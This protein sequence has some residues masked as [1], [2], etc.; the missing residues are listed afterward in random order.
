MKFT[1]SIGRFFRVIAWGTGQDD[2]KQIFI[3]F[4]EGG[5]IVNIASIRFLVP[6][7]KHY[8]FTGEYV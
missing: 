3:Y 7:L 8:S 2:V 1:H 4:Q 6:Q 5:E